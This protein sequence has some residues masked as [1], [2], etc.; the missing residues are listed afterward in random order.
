M[1]KQAIHPGLARKIAAAGALALPLLWGGCEGSATQ[2]TNGVAMEG[3]LVD[4]EG[5][6]VAGVE[7]K[8][9]ALGA[10]GTPGGQGVPTARALT[11][12]QG[13][14]RLTGLGAEV[15][16]IFGRQADGAKGI[17]IPDVAFALADTNLGIDTLV[18]PGSITGKVTAEDLPAAEVFCYIPGSSLAA[19]SDSGGHFTLSG[20][21]P[22]IYSLKLVGHDLESR[23]LA[24]I[25]VGSDSVTVLAPTPMLYDDRLGPTVVKGLSATLL[26]T[27]LSILR[28]TWTPPANSQI[29]EYRLHAAYFLPGDTSAPKNSIT[30]T[31]DGEQ[32]AQSPGSFVDEMGYA[33]FLDSN[34]R[35]EDSVLAEYRITAVDVRGNA[36]PAP[37]DPARLLFLRQP[38]MKSV[39]QLSERSSQSG[40]AGCAD[41]LAFRITMTGLIADT[42]GY[43]WALKLHRQGVSLGEYSGKHQDENGVT[44]FAVNADTISWWYGRHVQNPG[45]KPDSILVSAHVGIRYRG[46]YDSRELRQPFKLDSAGCYRAS[47]PVFDPR[48]Y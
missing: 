8:A 4:F 28:W 46:M 10:I 18:A 24:G 22:G 20:L 40:G 45:Y 41:T 11:D 25:R 1:H 6:P 32:L 33:I 13:R 43:S 29:R 44:H 7:V 27:A 15:Y 31:L 14:Y 48:I 39:M 26:D 34:F 17:L 47:G 38:W 21:P 16:N 5:H 30:L 37:S 35:N 9:F 3:R 19:I 42:V 36:S 2:T 23:I 12:R